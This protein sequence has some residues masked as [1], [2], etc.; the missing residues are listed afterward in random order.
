MNN[1]IDKVVDKVTAFTQMRYMKII[2]NGFM[3][4]T[5]ITICGSLFTLLKSLPFDPWLNF[6]ASSGL[7]NL[8]S[9]PVLITTDA[10]A[11]YVVLS[12]AYHTAKSFNHDGFAASLVALGSFLLLTPFSTTVYNADY[13][14][15]TEVT[16]VIP[17]SAIGAQ[18]IFLAILVGIIAAKIYVFFIDKGWKIKMPASVPANVSGM[19]EGLVPGGLTFIVF[20]LIRYGMSL[21]SFGTAQNFIYTFLQAPL[22]SVGGGLGGVIVY[23]F[24]GC[25]LWLFGIH[26][27]MVTYVGMITIVQVMIAENAGAFASGVACPHPEWAVF[28]FACLGGT[29]ATLALNV[30]MLSPI[31]KS[32]QYK[33]LGKIALPSSIFNINEPIIFG[34]PIVMN[35]LLAVPFVA[36]PLI[37]L[38]VCMIGNA[39]GFFVPTGANINN[40]MPFGFYGALLTGS[41]TGAVMQIILL[42][43]DIFVWLPF[44]K[45]ADNKAYKEEQVNLANQ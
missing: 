40:F 36:T 1:I 30:L 37:N 20:L 7:G 35:P 19:F 11:L 34:T 43:V 25:F 8:L 10:I 4:V 28:M 14:V 32:E 2:M 38:A 16:N 15:A 45:A 44:F 33:T 23:L 3:G 6:L 26:G 9:I 31:C 39:I 42:V 18:G 5:A 22:A 21:T 41:W 17:L 24:V 27:S 29:G 12:M 13:T